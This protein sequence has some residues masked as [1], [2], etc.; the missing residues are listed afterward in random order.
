MLLWLMCT[1]FF[2]VCIVLPRDKTANNK[3]LKKKKHWQKGRNSAGDWSY[4]ERPKE[5]SAAELSVRNLAA[6]QEAQNSVYTII[7]CLLPLQPQTDKFRLDCCGGSSFICPQSSRR[8]S[9]HIITVIRFLW[10][11]YLHMHQI[12]SNI[13]IKL[14]DETL[15]LLVSSGL[16]CC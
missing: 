15:T 16:L 14:P 5:L 7:C 11:S 12:L 9:W 1:S 6:L 2:F 10:I 3:P 13:I 8:T 4:S